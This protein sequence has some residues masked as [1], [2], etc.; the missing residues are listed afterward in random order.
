MRIALYSH[1]AVGLGHIRRNLLIANELS[2]VFAGAEFLFITGCSHAATASRPP[3]SSIC[4]LPKMRKD[5]RGRYISATPGLSTE[6]VLRTR[7]ALIGPALERFAPDFF[8]VD[9]HPTGLQGELLPALAR[10][11]KRQSARIVLGLRDIID[12]PAKVVAAWE[13]NGTEDAILEYY[14]RIWVYGDAACFDFASEYDLS[15]ELRTRLNYTGYFMRWPEIAAEAVEP[16][17][18]DSILCTVGGGVDG[19]TLLGMMLDA[20]RPVGTRLTLLLGPDCPE[21]AR[22]AICAR[23]AEMEDVCVLDMHAAPVALMETARAVVSMGGYNTLSE[24]VSLG[25]PA[26][27]APRIWPR[28]E[29]LIR[30]RLFADRGLI[31]MLDPTALNPESIAEWIEARRP[32]RSPSPVN[33]GGRTA[34]HR[35]AAEVVGYPSQEVCVEAPAEAAA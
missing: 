12:D 2:R 15:S 8:I 35:L 30:A 20:P 1:D 22:A 34:L 10:L 18:R 4:R 11:R 13:S 16:D 5:G 24:I 6:G 31:D 17:L 23:A 25:R 21:P 26:L 9:S 28:V 33:L 7:M 14:D 19:A 32:P 29:Q 27:V 3:H